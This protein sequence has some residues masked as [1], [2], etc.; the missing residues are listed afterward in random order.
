MTGKLP[1]LTWSRPTFAGLYPSDDFEAAKCDASLGCVGD[2]Y[3]NVR[4]SLAEKDQ[5]KKVRT[6]EHA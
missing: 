6:E 1:L 2:F 3:A 4:P 5:A